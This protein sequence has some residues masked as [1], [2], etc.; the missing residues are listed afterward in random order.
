MMT[1][2]EYDARLCNEDLKEYFHYLTLQRQ[3]NPQNE[4]VKDTMPSCRVLC[5]PGV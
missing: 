3:E 4:T 5:F 1:F 2:A